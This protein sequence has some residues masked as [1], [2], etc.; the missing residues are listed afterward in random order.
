MTAGAAGSEYYAKYYRDYER[1]N[2]AAKLQYYARLVSQQLDRSDRSP[3]VHD[4]GCAFGRFLGAA[5][6]HWIRSGS[7]ANHYALDV[8]REAYPQV[9]FS[10]DDQLEVPNSFDA[11]TAFDVLE[12]IED[13]DGTLARIAAALRP[14]GILVAVMPV[15]DGPLGGIV[16]ALDRDPTHVHRES[17]RFWFETIARHLDIVERIGITRYLLPWGYYVH[18][19]LSW[20]VP[21]APAVAIVARK[22]A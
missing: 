20:T 12:H 22:G 8:A 18:V 4:L 6:Q 7:D 2:P 1:Q 17:R 16:R 13:V 3:R 21:I 10:A 19:P 15:Y 14:R 11:V 9:T 5:P